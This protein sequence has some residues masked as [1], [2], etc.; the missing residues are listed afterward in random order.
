[1]TTDYDLIPN[2]SLNPILFSNAFEPKGS[3]YWKYNEKTS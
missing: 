2:E 1:M 3:M